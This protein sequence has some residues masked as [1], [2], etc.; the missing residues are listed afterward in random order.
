MNKQERDLARV[1][2]FLAQVGVPKDTPI[3]VLGCDELGCD[4]VCDV[5][6]MVWLFQFG[7]DGE[8][9][10]FCADDRYDLAIS[11][12]VLAEVLTPPSNEEYARRVERDLSSQEDLS[13]VRLDEDV[14]WT[15]ENRHLIPELLCHGDM[16]RAH[17]RV[18]EVRGRYFDI[19]RARNE[20]KRRKR[21]WGLGRFFG[22]TRGR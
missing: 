8:V 21:W 1:R 14:Q 9:L 7:R 4:F 13:G 2:W 18:R 5:D 22:P 11:P 12:Q 15:R 16:D 3:R 10:S 6:G 17:E 20:E 19:W